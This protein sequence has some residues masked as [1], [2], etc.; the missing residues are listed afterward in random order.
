[1]KSPQIKTGD[2]SLPSPRFQPPR[3]AAPN[4]AALQELYEQAL[5]PA[6]QE[7]LQEMKNASFKNDVAVVR[8]LQVRLLRMAA[9][10]ETVGEM[11]EL[12]QAYGMSLYRMAKVLEAE[13]R[14][15]K[16]Q[17]PMADVLSRSLS[18]ALKELENGT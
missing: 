18:R 5:T 2:G 3:Q 17:D 1:V 16:D 12:L 9:G 6:E 4:R 10:V 14:Q 7:A 15:G 13:Q 11:I 8:I